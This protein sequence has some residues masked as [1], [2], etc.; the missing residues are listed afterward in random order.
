MSDDCKQFPAGSRLRQI[1]DG[2]ADLP[3]YKINAYL[4]RWGIPPLEFLPPID[5]MS[6]PCQFI[7][8][9]NGF[10]KCLICGYEH[11]KPSRRAPIRVCGNQPQRL[12][13]TPTSQ[14]QGEAP[15]PK[16]RQIPAR[17]QAGSQTRPKRPPRPLLGDSVTSALESIGI[18]K[19]RVESWLGRPCGCTRR[20]EKL[21]Q[22]DRWARRILGGK[23]EEA[24]KHLEDILNEGN[25]Q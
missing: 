23:T 17:R 13:Y 18:T 5:L 12:V 15:R 3:P 8:Q 25:P 19:D 11:R 14:Q 20:Q 24:E 9:D 22:L 7:R 16:L 2:V 1:C 6:N 21:N 4:K 10:W